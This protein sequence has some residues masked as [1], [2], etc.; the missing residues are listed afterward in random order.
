MRAK[1]VYE[2][3]SFE[4]GGDPKDSMDI[5]ETKERVIKK[6]MSLPSG[7]S[8]RS[9]DPNQQD[10][11]NN[12]TG[13]FWYF[14]SARGSRGWDGA[15][16]SKASIEGLKRYYND[17]TY[18]RKKHYILD[19]NLNFERG[20]D[21]KD[22]M[23]IGK[24]D[25]RMTKEA[26]KNLEYSM[27]KLVKEFGGKYEI[28]KLPK[29]NNKYGSGEVFR[30]HGYWK[31]PEDPI[32]LLIK[33]HIYTNGDITQY[34]PDFK[35][36]GEK[37]SGYHENGSI[38]IEDSVE[39]LKSNFLEKNEEIKSFHK[40]YEELNKN[41]YIDKWPSVRKFLDDAKIALEK[42]GLSGDGIEIDLSNF[43]YSGDLAFTAFKRRGGFY[44][45]L[46]Y[47]QPDIYPEG[48]IDRN[49]FKNE[50]GIYIKGLHCQRWG[51]FSTPDKSYKKLINIINEI[52]I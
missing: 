44:Y 1:T 13:K 36:R 51:P 10:D 12:Q 8:K 19:E 43:G 42:A 9:R 37:W 7:F 14:T 32:E 38:N 18:D 16:L 29:I 31:N 26:K 24:K 50:P 23:D 48:F 5:G 33:S 4:R 6:I 41:D 17:I 52:I 11:R 21:P 46:N 39:Y 20:V 34:Y 40:R 35:E 15:N 30:I 3:L 25:V 49:G 27:G 45:W 2:N 28:R 47:T 22:A